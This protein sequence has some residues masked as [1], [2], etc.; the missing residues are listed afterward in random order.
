MLA[1][2]P[3]PARVAAPRYTAASRLGAT[4]ARRATRSLC[5]ALPPDIED[6]SAAVPT[7]PVRRMLSESR[8]KTVAYRQRYCCAG[9]DCLLPPNYEVD[10]IVPLAL[11]GTNGLTNLQALCVKCHT[12]KTRDQRHD[13]LAAQRAAEAEGQAAALKADLLPPDDEPATAL[14]AAG[15]ERRARRGTVGE[16]ASG[17][18]PADKRV[19]T[20]AAAEAD[21]APRLL[22]PL[23]LLRG[24][25]RQQLAAVLATSGPVRLAAGP[26]TGKTRVLVARIAHLV[27][28]EKVSPQRVLAVSPRAVPARARPPWTAHRRTCRQRRPSP[29][30]RPTLS[31]PS[32]SPSPAPLTARA[33]PTP[34]PTPPGHI[35]QQGGARAARAS[36][37][38]ARPCRRRRDD[39]GDLPLALPRDAS[40]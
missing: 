22:S 18:E 20:A 21:S 15:L 32:L 24:M 33:P 37:R 2:L 38:S 6:G 23:Q 7:P 13:I 29:W 19:S 17:S 40:T 12:Q 4:V 28:A 14:T 30:R 1:Y 5:S 8:K 34:L 25:N 35:H 11:G 16:V 39:H 10:H 27:S 3:R 26:G 36:D 9:C 31:A